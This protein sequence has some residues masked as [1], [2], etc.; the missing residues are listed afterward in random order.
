MIGLMAC[1]FAPRQ[2][3]GSSTCR[4][5]GVVRA[6]VAPAAGD[7]VIT[8][9]MAKP[10]HLSATVAQWLE[11]TAHADRD[12]NGVRIS[13][14]NVIAIEPSV[15]ADEECLHLAVGEYAVFARSDDPAQNGNLATSG[16]FAFSLNPDDS[17]DVQLV[18]GTEVIDRVTWSTS[19]SGASLQLDPDTTDAIAN[20][21]PAT[22]CDA[23]T[24]Y[25]PTGGNMG[26]PGGA[27]VSCPRHV[28]DDECVDGTSVRPIVK[29]L[30][31]QLVITEFLANAHGSGSDA[32]QEWFEVANTGAAPFD[33]NGLAVSSATART[34]IRPQQ[35]VSVA[36]GGFALFAHATDPATNGGLPKVDATFSFPLANRGG[37]L[38]VLDGTEILDQIAWTLPAQ[39]DGVSRG[40][41]PEFFN[42]VDND[43]ET[44]FCAADSA[45]G[46]GVDGNIGTPRAANVCSAPGP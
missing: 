13:R 28:G 7:L 27:N 31:G 34:E 23:T 3:R 1:G 46:Y 11:V 20:D 32:M 2:P 26:T 8:E 39:S 43:S 16:V 33:L 18:Y 45:S 15:I 36:P 6:V 9:I 5:D 21:E 10:K 37:V 4:D 44:R 19:T 25:E 35:C 17:P 42:V 24:V 40:L 12:L 22:F 29:P 38:R 41:P 14:A 30:P